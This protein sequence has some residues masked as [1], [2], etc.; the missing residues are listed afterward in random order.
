MLTGGNAAMQGFRKVVPER[1]E[2]ANEFFR[3]GEK[4]LLCEIHRRKTSG[5]TTSPSPP[6]F[7]APPH[8]PLFHH[9]GVSVA[10][11]HHQ[12]FVGDD[13]VIAAA[14]HG[15]GVLP[16][17][18]PHW[19][20]REQ[21]QSAAPVATRLLALGPSS[22]GG[23]RAANNAAAAGALM[24]ENERLRRSNAALLQELSHMRKLYNDIIY[25]VQNHVRPVAPSPAAAT[26][27]QGLGLQAP[28]RKKQPAT[29]AA[30]NGLNTSGGSTTS[31]SSLTIADELSPPPPHHLAAEKSGGEGAGSSSA[32]RSSAAAPTKL[33]GVHLSATPFGAG[34]KRPPSPEAELPSTPPATKPRLLLE[35][36]DL[37]LSV[38]Q[39][40]AATSS[41][42]R[43]SS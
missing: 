26:F 33:F 29:A 7:F 37:S 11:H 23:S 17:M 30:G 20:Q 40:C 35:C 13:G 3:K 12:Q 19:Q 41:P 22:E 24:A 34:S 6:P 38:A 25:F 42:A 10:Q 4:Q 32:A 9:P 14:A 8:F 18:Q 16:F 39:P 1:W 27:L 31:S 21:S 43:A 36:D 2:F 5:S 28:A 15:M